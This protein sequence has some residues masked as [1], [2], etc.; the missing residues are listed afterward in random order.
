ML[1][2]MGADKLIGARSQLSLT[3]NWGQITVIANIRNNY[4]LTPVFIYVAWAM[5][6]VG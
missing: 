1:M 4:V 3:N 5:V 6:L 2:A